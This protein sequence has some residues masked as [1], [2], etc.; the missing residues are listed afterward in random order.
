MLMFLGR[1]IL[2][3]GVTLLIYQTGIVWISFIHGNSVCVLGTSFKLTHS[4]RSALPCV[5]G[6]TFVKPHVRNLAICQANN[7]KN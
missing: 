5:Y 1:D 4:T 3:A 2:L 6:H 7:V